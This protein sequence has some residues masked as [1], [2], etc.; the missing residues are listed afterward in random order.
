MRHRNDTGAALVEA[1]IIIPF[2]LLLVFGVIDI[3]RAFFDAAAVQ[4]A[5]QEGVIYASHNPTDPTGAI[6]RTEQAVSTP[7]FTG[8]VTITCPASDQVEVTVTYTF[9]PATPFITS[10]DLT[11]AEIGQVLK[12]TACT[13]SP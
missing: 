1:A 12:S 5:A 10:F 11:H 4:E 3:A 2:V 8:A 7:D 9:S 13:P 6:T